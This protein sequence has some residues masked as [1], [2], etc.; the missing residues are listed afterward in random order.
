MFETNVDSID[1]IGVSHDE[2]FLF[3]FVGDMRDDILK[4]IEEFSFKGRHA[5]HFVLELSLVTGHFPRLQRV[6]F[7]FIEQGYCFIRLGFLR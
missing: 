7:P 5:T 1:A 3:A 4:A 6:F 2:F